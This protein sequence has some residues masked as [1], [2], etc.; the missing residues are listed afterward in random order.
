MDPRN[1]FFL[2]I[3]AQIDSEELVELVKDSGKAASIQELPTIMM[4]NLDGLRIEHLPGAPTEIAARTGYQFFK[5]EP[6]GNQWTRI[7]NEFSF[8]LSLGKLENADVSLYV[9][10]HEA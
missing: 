6:H 10:S 2:G 4:M 3:K 5:V 1:S 9:V 7:K 8:A